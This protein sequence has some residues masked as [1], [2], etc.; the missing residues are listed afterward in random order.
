[1]LKFSSV[2]V[3]MRLVNNVIASRDQRIADLAYSMW[4]EDGRP[5]GRAEAHWLRAAVLVDAPKK[6]PAVKTAAV[7]KTPKKK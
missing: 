3:N 1:L 7:P 5:E 6:K 2:V 4:E